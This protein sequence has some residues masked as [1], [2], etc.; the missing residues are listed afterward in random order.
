[1]KNKIIIILVIFFALSALVFFVMNSRDDT[2]EPGLFTSV[3]SEEL[4]A[5]LEDEDF[6]FIDVHTPEQR[7]IPGT[8]YFISYNNTDAMTS[9]IEDKDAKVV[10]YCRSGSMSKI[11]AQELVDMGYTNVYELT[12]G[13]HDW[14]SK[15]RETLPEGSVPVL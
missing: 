10:L 11:A 9:V 3:S 2:N 6:V 7:H 8:D 1:M 5:M 13:L 4:E 14:N 12:G 15:G